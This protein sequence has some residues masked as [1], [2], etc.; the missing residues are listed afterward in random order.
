M[1]SAMM[2]GKMLDRRIRT[3]TLEM[4]L[5][6][7]SLL[8][9]GTGEPYAQ[10][11]ISDWPALLRSIAHPELCVGKTYMDG[12]WSAGQPGL[13]PLLELLMRNF[14]ER[15]PRGPAKILEFL[16]QTFRQ[17]NP[18]G[19]SYRNVAAHYEIQDW[20][21]GLFLDSDMHYSCAYFDSP[22]RTLEQAQQRKCELLAKKL[23]LQPGMKVLD[24]GCGWGGLARHLAGHA[25]VSVTGIT[26][27]PQQLAEAQ[28]R[29]QAA[30]LA[31][32][33]RF[34]LADY[35]Q[36]QGRYDRIV[37]V[38]MFEHVGRPNYRRFFKRLDA[39][40]EADGVAVLHTIGRMG[41]K[42]FTNPWIQRYIFP[43]GYIPALSEI[44][45]AMESVPL[46]TTDIEVLREHYALTLEHWLERYTAHRD[47]IRERLGER[48]CR[49]WE[50]YLASCAAAFRWR[51]LVVFQLQFAKRL[52]SAVP[53]TRDYLRRAT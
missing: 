35:R 41:S 13:M 45:N 7:G 31:H 50:F 5:P 12:L 3:G 19:R 49:M 4:Q 23:C 16:R 21:Y 47:T 40:L 26:V 18:V 29:T 43:G 52:R 32:R 15:V 6:D 51:D 38:G 46:F 10:C 28:R 8:K 37:S 36:H 17:L 2:L 9:T 39:M 20:L 22:E 48:F 53:I 11:V 14:P 30:G 42:G 25:G 24:I 44:S 33:V 27:S 1:K 34:E